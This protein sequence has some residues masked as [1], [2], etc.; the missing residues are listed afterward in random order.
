[1]ARFQF[2]Q[3]MAFNGMAQTENWLWVL[4]HQ[5]ARSMISFS[6][7]EV[8]L[9][10]DPGT[11]WAGW[12]VTLTP[13]TSFSLPQP[14]ETPRDAF[15]GDVARVE[16]RNPDGVLFATLDQI[17]VSEPPPYGSAPYEFVEL[18]PAVIS[19]QGWRS[20]RTTLEMH[21]SEGADDLRGYSTGAGNPS[22]VRGLRGQ[23]IEGRG[24]DDVIVGG[25]G[26]DRLL[27]G[28]G[29]DVITDEYNVGDS[30][31]GGEGDDVLTVRRMNGAV[32]QDSVLLEGGGGN[33]RLVYE[34]PTWSRDN[35]WAYLRGGE[36]DDR[37]EAVNGRGEIHAGAGNDHVRLTFAGVAAD[38]PDYNIRLG[39]GSDVLALAG[40]N[41]ANITVLD[42][43][44]GDGGDRFDFSGLIATFT[45]LDGRSPFSS[46]HMRLV[47]EGASTLVQYD[48]DGGGDSYVTIV[49]LQNTN[50]S[51]LTPYN[52]G[53]FGT[54]DDEVIHGTDGVD[55]LDGG[56][57]DDRVFGGAGQDE[58]RG[59][60]GDDH[61]S[62]GLGN[63]RVD[64][65]PGDD[66]AVFSGP[67]SAYTILTTDS[68]EA[69]M[70]SGPEG[71]DL[72]LGI[73]YLQ[74][75]DG[76]FEGTASGVT[77][78]GTQGP[79]SI[80]GSNQAD[81]L[82]GYGG[83]DIIYGVRGSDRIYGGDGS[84][85]LVGDIGRDVLFGEAG[86]D[87]LYGRTGDDSI[88]G[89]DG[90]DVLFGE[91]GFDILVGG[92]GNDSLTGGSGFD[93]LYG[94]DGDDVL[95]GASGGDQI[96][97]EAGADRVYAGSGAD[98][99][100]GGDGADV[101]HGEDG[102]DILA[103]QG[104]ADIL[105]GGVG[106][107]ALYGGLDD[108]YIVGE[109]GSDDLLGEEGNDQLFGSLGN[110]RIAGGDGADA[111]FGEDG[112]DSITGGLGND[113]LTGGAGDDLLLGEAGHDVLVGEAGNDQLYGQDG[114]DG[115][116]A[117]DGADYLFGGA[118]ADALYGGA[119]VDNFV[120][121]ATTDAPV[122]SGEGIG[123]FNPNEDR[124]DL[125][126]IDADV[127]TAGNQAFRFVGAFTG[128]A[129]EAVL[130]YDPT[131]NGTH[132]LADVNGDGVAD[133]EI[134]IAGAVNGSQGWVL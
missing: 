38:P 96:L 72:L 45:G 39:A 18:T 94:G 90:D 85:L 14:G 66:T 99:V 24:G 26:F 87:Q 84:D 117:G 88:T 115:L 13:V 125:A 95:V 52:L 65:G 134:I 100:T 25:N 91:S 47:Q 113:G 105:A 69:F 121:L 10:G 111:L 132:F 98:I 112:N 119:G 57:G 82:V 31:L 58:V 55:T 15:H 89:G 127:N 54:D 59:G 64:G 17:T 128:S 41:P 67:R 107:D 35:I 109:D 23:T 33:D 102:W 32:S 56:G 9:R 93:I 101:L 114:N 49:R 43:Q 126:F 68:P 4:R 133:M 7:G 71:N 120:Y 118:G 63:D 81:V 48:R 3:P 42:F 28:D 130:L 129:G 123:D 116:Y 124:I 86:N 92:L 44:A 76:S 16:L 20:W 122:G 80:G 131:T 1:M 75:S 74:F 73:E 40:S 8:V 34:T 97:G 103:G 62:G 108:D 21:G 29:N 78:G 50:A 83:D 11:P 110:D 30:L 36:G 104:G 60:A 53:G 19:D 46:G 12:T 22:D 70:V 2:H 6:P 5:T 27:G 61:V 106:D 51:E 37:I 77:I 79:D